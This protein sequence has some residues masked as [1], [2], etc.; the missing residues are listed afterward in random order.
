MNVE[1]MGGASF[2]DALFKYSVLF[3]GSKFEERYFSAGGTV[4][5]LANFTNAKFTGRAFFR[6]VLFGNDASAYS[7][8]TWPE[9]RADFTNAKFMGATVFRK[10]VFCGAPAFFEATLHEDTDFADID[11]KR[12]DT[13]HIPVDFAIRA[14]ERLELMMSKLEKPLDRHKFYRLKMRVRRR[15][16]PPFLRLL[17]WLFETTSDYGWGVG[18][19]FGWWFAHWAISGL[20]LFGSAFFATISCDAAPKWWKLA[21]AA[22]GTS[23]ANAHMFLSLVAQGGDLEASRTMLAQN[24]AWGL[25]T[26]IGASEAVFGPIFL[27]LLLLTLRNRFRL[28]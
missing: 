20:A 6:G 23:F 14:W 19:A 7:L 27:F 11:W 16:D 1:F 12:A 17:N 25:L 3:D 9:R 4:Q 18:R 22:L 8:R 24:D 5:S 21:F 26:P 13:D 2:T 28:A 15:A 10:A